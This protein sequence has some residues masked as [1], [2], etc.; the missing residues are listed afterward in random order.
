MTDLE[1]AQHAEIKALKRQVL[2]E[3]V[4]RLSAELQCAQASIAVFQMRIPTLQQELS[5]AQH[6]LAEL[7]KEADSGTSGH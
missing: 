5:L 3:Q 7:T 4:R 1:K 2:Q 6:K